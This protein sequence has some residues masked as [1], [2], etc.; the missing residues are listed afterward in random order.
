[1]K[2]VT[3]WGWTLSPQ[4]GYVG[5]GMI[6]GPRTC[7]SMLGGAL[8]GFTVL[9]PIAKKKGWAPGAI[10]STRDGATGTFTFQSIKSSYLLCFALVVVVG[11][12]MGWF[13]TLSAT[14]QFVHI[15]Y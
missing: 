14:F 15:K 10:S 1:M 13:I 6:M 2:T 7:V 9:G 4:L 11:N 8:L 3:E 5:Q 12:G